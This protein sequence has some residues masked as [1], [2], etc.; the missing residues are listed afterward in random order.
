MAVFARQSSG[1]PEARSG[2]RGE[3]GQ[4]AVEFALV[5][6]ILCVIVLAIVD[7]GKAM[8]YWLDL[9]HVASETAR[10]AAVNAYPSAGQYE[11]YARA[12]L[13]TNELKTGGTDSI[14]TAA[15]VAICLPDGKDVGDAVTVQVAV[16][17]NWIPFIDGP[18]WNIRGTATMRIEQPADYSA[19]GTCT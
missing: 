4:A 5:V 6:P 13:E 11:T 19:S 16:S 10:R 9:N 14:P 2:L 18:D 7:F 1:A 17:Y 15:S 8:N 3:S 12:R